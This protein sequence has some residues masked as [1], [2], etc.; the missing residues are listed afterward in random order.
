LLPSEIKESGK[1]VER[2]WK[3]SGKKVE[4]KWKESGK[5]VITM[6]QNTTEQ[7]N[8]FN[9]SWLLVSNIMMMISWA[10]TLRI[11]YQKFDVLQNPD[12]C[13][14]LL[15]DD[16]RFA[17][18]VSFL[19]FFNA[20]AGFTRSKPHQVLFFN[21]IRFGVENF[22]APLLPCS[23]WL[24]LFTVGCWSL[25]DTVRFGCFA[26]DILV[27][28]GRLAKSVRYTVGPMLFPFGAAGEMLM[29][30]AIAHDDRP[31]LYLLAAL[32]PPCF[33]VLMKQL[34]RQRAK[35]FSQKKSKST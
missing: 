7:M 31:L 12:S 8:G 23:S 16:L 6:S 3:E 1:K 33:F 10:K 9:R 17:L 30:A 5:K 21:L 4:R 11:L 32:W 35:F 22:A 14:K 27:P 34:L 18:L 19:E 26:L 29:V 20:L 25:G 13:A 15:T 2:K 28:G 24:H